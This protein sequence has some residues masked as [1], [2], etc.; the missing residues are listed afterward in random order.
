MPPLVVAC[1]GGEVCVA[2]PGEWNLSVH[3]SP[4]LLLG[5]KKFRRIGWGQEFNELMFEILITVPGPE[6]VFVQ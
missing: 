6:K 5:M 1:Q 4:Y 2:S 3:L